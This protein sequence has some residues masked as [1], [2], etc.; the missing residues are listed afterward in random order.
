M[1]EQ[2]EGNP[3]EWSTTTLN[4]SHATLSITTRRT[5]LQSPCPASSTTASEGETKFNE[6]LQDGRFC[7]IELTQSRPFLCCAESTSQRQLN[8][9]TKIPIRACGHPGWPRPLA[10]RYPGTGSELKIYGLEALE[11]MVQSCTWVRRRA[12][13]GIPSQW[14]ECSQDREIPH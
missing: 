10:P 6:A 11:H 8:F 13:C 12:R 9:S 2:F 1:T 4:N 3:S 14:N 7:G 5:P